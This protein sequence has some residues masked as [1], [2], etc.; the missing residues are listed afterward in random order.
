V[1][2]LNARA[3]PVEV[4]R[5]SPGESITN[6]AF[7]GSE[8][9]EIFCTNSTTGCVMRAT[10]DVAGLTPHGPHNIAPIAAATS[11]PTRRE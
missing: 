10:M 11:S 6:L 7:G 2:V 3:E 9:K 1:W 5:A 8:M 4:L